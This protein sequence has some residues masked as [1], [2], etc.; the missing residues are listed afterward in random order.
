V[1]ESASNVAATLPGSE[2]LEY[3]H[4]VGGD[5]SLETARIALGAGNIQ[6]VRYIERCGLEV[7][8]NMR[9]EKTEM[10]KDGLVFV[11]NVECLKYALANGC[12]VSKKSTIQ[13]AK[14]NCLSILQYC[15]EELNIEFTSSDITTAAASEGALECL[16]YT[17]EHGCPVTNIALLGAVANNHTACAAYLREQGLTGI[18]G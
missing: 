3:I 5:L 18:H 17:H 1:D 11:G 6:G 13:F 10:A 9:M 7:A 16:V 15:H 8:R 4:S 14:C 2:I 12:T